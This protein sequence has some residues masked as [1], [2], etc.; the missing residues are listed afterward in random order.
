MNGGHALSFAELGMTSQSA[1]LVANIPVA[2][3]LEVVWPHKFFRPSALACTDKA[4]IVAD[5]FAIYTAEPFSSNSSLLLR[6]LVAAGVLQ[7][8]FRALA[9]ART[10]SGGNKCPALL[11]LERPGLAVI[12]HSLCA[13]VT[14]RWPLG[15]SLEG[16]LL[17]IALMDDEG[18]AALCSPAAAAPWALYGVT[19]RGEVIALCPMAGQIEPMHVVLAAPGSPAGDSAQLDNEALSLHLDK[20]GMLSML[21]QSRLSTW[22]TESGAQQGAWQLPRGRKWAS[23]LCGF[24]GGFIAAS[25]R[26]ADLGA[27]PEVWWFDTTE[28]NSDSPLAQHEGPSF[29]ARRLTH[30][31]QL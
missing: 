3:K 10:G 14:V 2:R 8:P 12:E 13:D 30:D 1:R 26:L 22:V 24:D 17:S 6:P 16:V 7:S 28:Q 4:L 11:L 15:R 5:K 9:A 21:E 25:S 18:A 20:A 29:L 27:H 19:D 23:G 31:S